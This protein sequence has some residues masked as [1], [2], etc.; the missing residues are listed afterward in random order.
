MSGSRFFAGQHC[1]TTATGTLLY[2]QGL[3][4]SEPMMFG[5]GEGLGFIFL[6]LASLNLP[7]CGGRTK[8]FEITACLCRNL[9]INLDVA[10]T[11][12]KA[13]AWDYLQTAIQAGRSVG[14][15]LDSYYLD[16]FSTKIH[17][18]A[19]FVAAYDIQGDDVLLVD[20]LQQGGK[21]KTSK[22]SLEKGRFAKG[23]MTAKARAWTVDGVPHDP[24][25]REP[26]K[27]AIRNNASAY[28]NPQFKGMNYLGIMKLSESLPRWRKLAKTPEHDL[29]LASTLMERA[30]TG[31]GL[32]RC[33]YR[34]F[35]KECSELLGSKSLKASAN[36]F[37]VIADNWQ[38]VSRL[39]GAAGTTGSDAPLGQ[40]SEI[41]AS[42]A[43]QEK[44]AFAKLA[45]LGMQDT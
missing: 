1:E 34:D 7:F 10:E 13:R 11:S 16:Y 38:Q 39:I 22:G 29:A 28:L 44:A 25:L 19:H 6:N 20:T 24:S 12:S 31:G 42:L 37:S 18:G 23:P 30:G 40:A 32:F 14:L 26:I 15:Q 27:K 17:F 2:Q 21:Q 33:F 35:L 3:C 43:E 4:L 9:G 45:V 36:E 5:L 8:P 41:C